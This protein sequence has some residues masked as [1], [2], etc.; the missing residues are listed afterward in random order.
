MNQPNNNTHDNFT[1]PLCDYSVTTAVRVGLLLGSL[2]AVWQL[3]SVL[4]IE[5]VPKEGKW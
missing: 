3:V 2:E 1:C 5:G 4:G